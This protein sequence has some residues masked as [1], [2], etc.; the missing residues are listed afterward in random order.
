MEPKT[1]R[2]LPKVI[3][4]AVCAVVILSAVLSSLKTSRRSQ[5]KAQNELAVSEIGRAF[6]S[7]TAEID[8]PTTLGSTIK[9]M[10]VTPRASG[11]VGEM[12]RWLKTLMNSVAAQRNEYFAE[13]NAIGW[14][15][16]LD[17]KRLQADRGLAD[18]RKIVR[19]AKEIVAKARER[20]ETLLRD[21]RAGINNLNVSAA[22]KRSMIAGFDRKYGSNKARTDKIWELEAQTVVEFEKIIEVLARD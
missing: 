6:E 8:K 15:K 19:Q 22:A 4:A 21:A 11:D 18:S 7:L 5:D 12:E 17:G 20:S 9:P 14:E 2:F 13:L 10:D 3:M 1:R 16:V